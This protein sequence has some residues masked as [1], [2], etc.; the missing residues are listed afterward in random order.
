[1]V[2]LALGGIGLSL[3]IRELPPRLV[4]FGRHASH[5]KNH[6][7]EF[8]NWGEGTH[9]SMAVSR[10]PSGVLHY[11]NAGKIQASSESR[12]LLLQRMLGHLATLLPMQASQSVLVIGCGAG[13]TA[14][15]ASI[16]SRVEQV[17]IGEI[18]PLVPQ[19]VAGCFAGP[20]FH[21]VRNPKVAVTIWGPLP[22]GDLSG[23]FPEGLI[24]GNS[25]G[26]AFR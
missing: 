23:C 19:V 5:W 6:Q 10:L 4:G 24:F 20:N 21:V 17:R 7:G 1:M 3:A 25:A 26:P 11:H 9:S 8:L 22:F 13:I 2:F 12:G 14:G 16:D 15:S 18:E